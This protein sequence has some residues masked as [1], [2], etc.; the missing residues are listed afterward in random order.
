MS[1][2][3]AMHTRN[4]AR[5]LCKMAL[6]KSAKLSC[7]QDV[8][9]ARWLRTTSRK[10]IGRI[11]TQKWKPG[12][13]MNSTTQLTYQILRPVLK[14]TLSHSITNLQ[15]K[16]ELL[17]TCHVWWLGSFAQWIFV[18]L[19]LNLPGKLVIFWLWLADPFFQLP[20]PSLGITEE[21][22]ISRSAH[23]ITLASNVLHAQPRACW[24]DLCKG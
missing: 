12:P 2:L 22:A 20:P 14:E 21:G 18:T 17:N 8:K 24:R 19:W 3:D 23:A 7:G 13:A 16:I 5:P 4:G 6:R 10:W 1:L 11:G 15:G 9:S